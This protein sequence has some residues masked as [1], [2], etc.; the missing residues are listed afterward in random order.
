MVCT[1]IHIYAFTHMYITHSGCG[2]KDKIQVFSKCRQKNHNPYMLITLKIIM[3]KYISENGI[4]EGLDCQ[5]LV[6]G[7]LASLFLSIQYIYSTTSIW[8]KT[9]AKS[10]DIS[11]TRKTSEARDC[12]L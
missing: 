12:N 8:T 1:I 10:I 2:R 6:L 5:K 9:E 3:D 11:A 4:Y 7:V